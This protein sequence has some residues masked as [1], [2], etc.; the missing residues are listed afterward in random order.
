MLDDL[1]LN[2][3]SVISQSRIAQAGARGGSVLRWTLS[4]NHTVEQYSEGA[5]ESWHAPEHV[6]AHDR[7][8]AACVV[9]PMREGPCADRWHSVACGAGRVG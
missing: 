8:R 6:L 9:R 4:L 3:I 7:R 1:L 2:Q 5:G